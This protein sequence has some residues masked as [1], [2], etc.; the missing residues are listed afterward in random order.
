LYVWW[1]PLDAVRPAQFYRALGAALLVSL[2]PIL[3]WIVPVLENT[4]QKFAFWLVWNQT[5]GRITGNFSSAHVHPF[6]FYLP[7]VPVLLLPWAFF[8]VLWKNLRTLRVSEPSI[9][10]LISATLPVF[11][12]FSLIAGKQP[13]YLLPL[14]PFVM[15]AVAVLMAGYR[16]ILVKAVSVFM[17]VLIVGGQGVAAQMVFPRYDLSPYAAFYQEHKD[18]DWAFAPNYQG[19]IGFVARAEHP[20]AN[21]QKQDLKQ[22]FLEHPKGYALVR[23]DTRD[24][25]K[26]YREVLF[27]PYKGKWI[28]IYKGKDAQ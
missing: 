13:H 7:H 22:W 14:L 17:V 23:H 8:P 19:E 6:Y 16:G 25:V 21:I 20:L 2:I 24:E 15:I 28:G 5:A 18:A 3:L 26:D 9:R 27:A 10:F 4:D 12:S 1:R 11:I